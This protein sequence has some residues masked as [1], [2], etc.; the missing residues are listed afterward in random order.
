MKRFLALF[1]KQRL[2]R[3]LDDEITAYL[4]LA[5]RDLSAQGLTPEQARMQARRNFGGIEQMKEQ[6]RDE[7]SY[8]FLENLARDFRYGISALK[9]K[10]NF[11]AV[12]IAVLALGIGA[13]TAM[14]SLIDAVLWKPIPF[15]EPDRIVRVWEIPG[16]NLRNNTATLTFLD[17]KHQTDVFAALSVES[18]TTVALST[19]ADPA[20][21]EGEM[22]SGD[23]FQVFGVNAQLGRTFAPN[24]DQ[25]GAAPVVI[26]SHAMWQSR[27][28]ADPR[29]LNR[30]I[31]LDGQPNRII[32]VLPAGSFDRSS[33]EFWKPLIFAPEQ[34]N[35]GAHWISAIGRLKEGVTID[36]ANAKLAI[37]RHSLDKEMARFKKDWTFRAEPFAQMLV[38]DNL[39]QSIYV[40]FGAVLMVLLIACAN[41]ANLLLAQ[42][43]ARQKEMALRAAL[44]ASRGRLMLQL[45]TESWVLC[46]LGGLVGIALAYALLKAT[47]PQMAPYLPFTAD[48]HIDGRVLAFAVVAAMSVTILV[49]LLPA[50]LTGTLH[51]SARGVS[52]INSLTRRM[53][54]IGEVAVSVVLLTGAALLFKSLTNLQRIDA[55]VR[56]DHVITMSTA[57]PLSAYPKAP[58]ATVFYHNLIDRLGAVPGVEQ[59]SISQDLPMQGVRGGELF[60]IP[61]GDDNVVV[62]FKRVDANYFS[63]LDIPIVNGRPINNR[64]RAGSTKVVVINQVLARLLSSK[65]GIVDPIGRT[66]RMTAPGY[67]KE[68]GAGADLQ[69]IGVIRNESTSDLEKP[70]DPVVYVPLDQYPREDFRILARTRQEP[71]AVVSGIREALRQLD[72]KLGLADIRTMEEVKQRNLTWARQP[73]WLIGTFALVAAL[74]AAL[75]VY[76]V[77][78]HAVV[79]QRREIGIR[80][81]L[82]ATAGKVLGRV[83]RNAFA[84]VAIGLAI[85]LSG[86]LALTQLMKALLFN[87]SPLDPVALATA[88]TCMIAIGLLAACL[89]AN[90][91]AKVDPI[92][93]LR[94]D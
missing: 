74:L 22:V 45:L 17:W 15:P 70:L 16:V 69:V 9:R 8:P 26:I 65:Y 53:I 46:L 20:R 63:A 68:D 28:G 5:E 85:G 18:P 41:V 81:A 75:G 43:A 6:H 60:Y 13:N 37:L 49:G 73:A 90:R 1:R 19:G 30:D 80:M 50:R 55:G 14:F 61:G 87:V 3:E 36:Q 2:D 94:E 76:G 29:I 92:T 71:T 51:H 79:Q 44:G 78:S 84:L 23:F 4:E 56:I 58:N 59:A 33:A 54:V 77:L 24:E 40:G 7:R 21:I 25:P 64:D 12:V 57:L 42:G 35:R 88:M 52:P 62:R 38:G 34:M 11:S 67:G 91:A 32:G 31:V 48:L 82:G 86:A 89:P 10:P 93:T 83:L 27:F 66:F 72:P 39:R 47:A